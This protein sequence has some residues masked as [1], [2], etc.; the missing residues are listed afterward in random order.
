VLVGQLASCA[1]TF[2]IAAVGQHA[3]RLASLIVAQALGLLTVVAQHYRPRP[4]R[5]GAA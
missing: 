5:A 4:A 2:R 1:S 3:L